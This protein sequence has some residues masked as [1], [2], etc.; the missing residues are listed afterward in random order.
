VLL[1]FSFGS[2]KV[3]I[4]VWISVWI[5]VETHSGHVLEPPD[6]RPQGFLVHIELTPHS[7]VHAH[8]LFGEITKRA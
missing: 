8:K 2:S 1:K 4:S 6:Q 5:V 3:S 7:L